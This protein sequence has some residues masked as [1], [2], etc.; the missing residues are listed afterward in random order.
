MIKRK[1]IE[2]LYLMV[3]LIVLALYGCV[4][5]L[6]G[7]NTAG[8]ETG[9]TPLVSAFTFV[10]LFPFVLF[11]F[12]AFLGKKEHGSLLR[13]YTIFN[14][15]ALFIILLMP[16]GANLNGTLFTMLKTLLP[17]LVTLV[18]YA[19]VK[20]NGL[21]NVLM[22]GCFV[23]QLVLVIQYIR[24]YEVAN[25]VDS[26]HIGVAYYPL[27]L[28][29]VLLLHPSKIIR[30]ASIAIVMVVL[31]SSM[32]RGGLLAFVLAMVAYIV[33]QSRV[34]S[35][36]KLFGLFFVL[37]SF[38]V[39]G[40]ALW[41]LSTSGDNYV[42]ERIM[43]IQEDQGSG[44]VD[45]W[46]TTWSMIMNSD[47]IG[48]VFG[49]GY[50]AVLKDSPLYLAAHNDWL[51]FFYDYGLLGLVL[52]FSIYIVWVGLFFKLIKEKAVVVPAMSF[53]FVVVGSL[54]LISHMFIGASW[55]YL[56][57]LCLGVFLGLIERNKE[58]V[59]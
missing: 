55:F 33:L 1:T 5:M 3:V 37:I 46:M 31:F 23:L 41:W 19:Y 27:L 4:T 43:N 26:A 9:L 52:Y 34:Q 38:F 39:L 49:H 40:G 11:V 13:R 8:L 14:I 35:R 30:Y 51:E 53:L 59:A 21:T 42:F 12:P 32:K 15:Y 54:S 56:A 29:P 7:D 47:P 24:L 6:D 18:F 17:F 36:N 2:T 50:L 45:V 48:F 28:L 22:W 58:T 10:V 44:R 25:Q 16:N 57:T 20:R